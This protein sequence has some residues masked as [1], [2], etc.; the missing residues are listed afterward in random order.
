MEITSK[1]RCSSQLNLST[2]FFQ[3]M[4]D[5]LM[6][7]LEERGVSNDFIEKM[8]ELTTNKEHEMYVSLLERLQ[9]FVEGK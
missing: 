5:L 9:T 6:N 8:I 7:L 3:Y 4:Y 1:T 2:F